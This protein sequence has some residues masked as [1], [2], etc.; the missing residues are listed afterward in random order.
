M[1]DVADLTA[2]RGTTCLFEDLR[3]AVPRGTVLWLKGPNGAGKTTLLRII[4]GLT[5]PESGV[6]RWE[7]EPRKQGLRELAAYGSHQPALSPDLTVERNLS[8][9]AELGQWP[10]GWV[11]ILKPLGLERCRNLEVRRL[12]A[13]QRR[14]T[15]LVRVFNSGAPVWLLDEP[16]ANLDTAGRSFVEERIA[17]KAAAQGVVIVAMHEDVRIRG[18]AASSLEL[19][20]G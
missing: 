4:C 3:F 11:Q 14:R 8:F 6:M 12:S 19:G 10:T 9:Y 13:G 2:W 20:A 17:A 5:L 1:L 15:S 18:I 16:F 7:G